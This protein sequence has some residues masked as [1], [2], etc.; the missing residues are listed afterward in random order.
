M[1]KFVL[2]VLASLVLV[3]TGTVAK[4]YPTEVIKTSGGDLTISIIGHA[5]LM[6]QYGGKVIHVDSLSKMGDYANLPKA[7]LILITHEHAD[8]LDPEALKNIRTD[9]TMVIASEAAAEKLKGA[10]PMRNGDTKEA[11]GLK[12]E[13]VTAYNLVHMRE[14]GLPFHPKGR[15]NGYVVTFGDKRVYF[16]GDTENTPEMKA[17]KDIDVAFLPIN[18]P[19]TMTAEMVVDAVKGFK[20]KVLYPYHFAMGTTDVDK[21]PDLMNNVEGVELR[22]RK[23]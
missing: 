23:R 2:T 20:P 16:A 1:V 18:L 3:C 7:D 4:A 8:H 5:S 12:I 14:P 9:K 13:A 6:L 10:T 15:G 11:L 21:L 22:I 17:L 19:Y